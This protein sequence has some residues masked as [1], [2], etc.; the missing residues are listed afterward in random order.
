MKILKTAV[1]KANMDLWKSGLVIQTFGNASGA[2]AAEG[3]MA[4]K[5]SGVDYDECRWEDMVVLSIDSGE[6]IDGPLRPSSDTP[7]HLALYRAFPAIGGIVH[8]HSRYATSWAQS[9]RAIPCLGTT[10]ADYFYG[11][12]PVTRKLSTDEIKTD[13]EANT[14]KVITEYLSAATNQP[15]DV[16]AILVPHHGPFTWGKSAADA[17]H[18]AIALEEVARTALLTL[19]LNPEAVMPQELI[20]KHFRRKHGPDAYYGQ[21]GEKS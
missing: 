20:D 6:I 21:K 7:T 12:V 13:Y 1:W 9:G 8:T 5:P 2:D 18:S 3:V 15:F 10:H 11:P 4:I 14:G 17:V 19:S 16:P